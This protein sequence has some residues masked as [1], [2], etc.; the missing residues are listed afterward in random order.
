MADKIEY[1]QVRLK[2]GRAVALGKDD[3]YVVQFAR[4]LDELDNVYTKTSTVEIIDGKLVTAMRLSPE[5]LQALV[6]LYID[7]KE[8]EGYE[9]MINVQLVKKGT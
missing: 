9:L 7:D 1:R 5:A 2:G 3:G 6:S 4:P 8:K